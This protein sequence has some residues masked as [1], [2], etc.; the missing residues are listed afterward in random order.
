MN[1]VQIIGSGDAEVKIYPIRR[2]TTRYRFFQLAWYELGKR[3]T[4]TFVDALKAKSYAQQVHV[5][6]LN[7]GRAVDVTP[8]DVQ[9]LRDAEAIA[10]KFGVS[11]PFAIREWAD[12]RTLLGSAILGSAKSLAD[13]LHGVTEISITDVVER[14]IESKRKEGM[15]KRHLQT[16]CTL[17]RPF[18]KRFAPASI[19]SLSTGDVEGYISALRGSDR[20]KN[21]IAASLKSLFTWAKRRN[22]L[23]ADRAPVTDG[24]KKIRLASPTPEI[25]SPAEMEKILN[26]TRECEPEMLSFMAIGAFAGLR[27]AEIARLDWSAVDFETG[28]IKI[29]WDIAKTRQRRL[30]PI[31]ENLRAWLLL[32]PKR[33]GAITPDNHRRGI[34]RCAKKAEVLWK[35]NALRH[36]F[37]SYR[38]AEVQDAAKVSLEMGNSPAMLFK[39]YRQVVTPEQAKQWFAILPQPN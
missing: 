17:L 8:Q 14:F 11:L 33:K 10:T 28:Y 38:L 32:H 37:G 21:N 20:T 27:S 13:A 30:V 1:R 36:S 29:A 12:A 31:S 5:S 39:H 15:S 9:M 7:Q 23:R 2:K 19:S 16:L 6:L 35:S 25:F 18:A 24:L 4:K 3:R 26:A 34:T 22:H